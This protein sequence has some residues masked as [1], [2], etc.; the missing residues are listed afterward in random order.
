MGQPYRSW[1]ARMKTSVGLGVLICWTCA[2]AYLSNLRLFEADDVDVAP[3]NEWTTENAAS[4]EELWQ[5]PSLLSDHVPIVPLKS[6]QPAEMDDA[7]RPSTTPH[8]SPVVPR[9]ERTL[10]RVPPP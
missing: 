3:N 7:V 4:I 2:W 10:S 8:G 1:H 9:A 5:E 6:T